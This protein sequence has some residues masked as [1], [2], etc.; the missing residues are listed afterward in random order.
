[1][2]AGR[3]EPW[4]RRPRSRRDAPGSD[5]ESCPGPAS[6]FRQRLDQFRHIRNAQTGH[7]VVARSSLVGAIAA[8]G[9]VAEAGGSAQRV[10]QGIEEG[11]RAFLRLHPSLVDQGAKA[12]PN[13]RAPAR[14]PDLENPIVKHEKGALVGICGEADVEHQPMIARLDARAALPGGSG[15]TDALSAA[16]A[17]PGGL[18]GNRAVRCEL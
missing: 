14:S 18:T 8:L 6:L 9:D 13:R 3:I 17:C 10:D 5:L 4:S 7:H 16:A 1:M 11:E 15:K 2:S 12:S